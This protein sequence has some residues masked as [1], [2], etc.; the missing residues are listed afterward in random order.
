VKQTLA[1]VKNGTKM[2][3]TARLGGRCLIANR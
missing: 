2:C 1:I 3:K